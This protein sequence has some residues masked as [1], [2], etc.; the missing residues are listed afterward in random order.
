MSEDY[1]R[2]QPIPNVNGLLTGEL[3]GVIL[4]AGK[5][6]DGAA[7]AFLAREAG[8]IVTTHTGSPL[9]PISDCIGYQWPGIAVAATPEIHTDLLDL[10]LDKQDRV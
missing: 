1:S 5:F 7:L 9:P 3:G 4:A 2:T 6:I 10:I 8:H